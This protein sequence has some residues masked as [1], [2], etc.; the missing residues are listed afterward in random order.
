MRSS[1]WSS[2]VCSSDLQLN[3]GLT[4]NVNR[5]QIPNTDPNRAAFSSN[6]GNPALKPFKSTNLDL[7]VEQYFADGKGYVSLAGFYKDL[8]D[9]VNPSAARLVDF[10]QFV[11]ELLSPD[12][13]AALGT[14][15]GIAS[16]PSHPGEDRTS[17]V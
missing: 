10:S 8:N 11:D 17:V 3:A 5:T 15:L 12:E 7:S 1:D 9:F 14:T 6:G 16:G 2:D 13:Q 4:L